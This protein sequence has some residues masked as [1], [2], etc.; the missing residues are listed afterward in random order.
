MKV[1]II[2][3]DR[4]HRKT[5]DLASRLKGHDITLVAIPWV[6]RHSKHEPLLNHR[7]SECEQIIPQKLAKREGCDFH[8]YPLDRID[9]ILAHIKPDKTIIG[10]CGVVPIGMFTRNP[11]GEIINSHPGWLPNVR[12]LDAFKWTI[13]DN[14]PIGCTTYKISGDADT[15]WLID[16]KETPIYRD[17]DFKSLADRHYELEIDMLVEA[18]EKPVSD[19]YLGEKYIFQGYVPAYSVVHKRM[20]RDK[21]KLLPEILRH[22]VLHETVSA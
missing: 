2:T 21:E 9:E 17:D 1:A 8:H 10:G 11:T 15:G 12:G 14:E 4:P 7:P 18:V 19:T 3:Y 5:Q 13:Y 22:R 16:R 6:E 20:P